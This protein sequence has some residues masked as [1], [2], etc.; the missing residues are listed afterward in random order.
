LKWTHKSSRRLSAALSRLGYQASRNTVIRLLRE[1]GFSLRN[2]HKQLA[3]TGHRDRDEQYR[4]LVRLRR[5]YLNH[6]WPVISVDSK[7]KEWVGPFKNSGRSWR[8][9]PYLVFAHDFSSYATGP[10]IIYGIYDLAQNDGYVVVGTSHDTPV[11]AVAAIRRWW[12]AIGRH[13]YT[14]AARILIEA[15]SG[16]SNDHRKWEWKVALQHFADEFGLTVVMTH[17]PTGASKWNP[18][19][20]RMFSLISGNWAG[21]PLDTYETV[22]QFI[23]ATE[24]ETGFHCRA[25]LDV[26]EYEPGHRV[27]ADEKAYVRLQRRKKCPQWNCIIRPHMSTKG[28]NYF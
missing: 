18:I 19:D 3:E 8:R 5:L 28:S 1:M 23:R 9:R 21:K 15:D 14:K 7:K 22:L 25:T 27:T 26:H 11:F 10:A 13:R 20:H 4:Y 6:N 2:C 17:L 16:G 12:L 24:S